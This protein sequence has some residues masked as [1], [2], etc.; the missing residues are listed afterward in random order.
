YLYERNRY[1]EKRNVPSP[2]AIPLFG[3]LGEFATNPFGPKIRE[4]TLKYG[5]TYGIYEGGTPVLVTSDLDV[6]Q[7]VFVRKYEN[8]HG[9]KEFPLAKDPDQDKYSSMFHARGLRWKRLRAISTPVFSVKNMRKLVPSVGRCV[10]RFMDIMEQRCA[11][12]KPFDILHDFQEFTCDAIAHVALGETRNLQ[13]S[14]DNPYL[15]LCREFFP[16]RPT[17]TN[18][19]WQLLPMILPEIREGVTKVYHFYKGL[20]KSD[21]WN[22]L[23]LRVTKVVEDRKKQLASVEG[24]EA[25]DFVDLF[26]EAE[27]DDSLDIINESKTVDRRNLVF[28]RKLL[29]EEIVGQLML[30]L[31]AGY[32]TTSNSLGYVAYHLAMDPERQEKLR[33]EVLDVTQGSSQI[34]YEMSLDLKYTEQCIKE[35]L[36]LY[37]LASFVQARMCMEPCTVGKDDPIEVPKGLV[38]QVDAWSIQRDKS[39]WGEDP[40]DFRPERFD[41]VDPTTQTTH[42]IPFGSGPRICIGMRFSLMEQKMLLAR[43]LQKYRIRRCDKTAV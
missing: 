13:G 38:I 8:F 7:D 37:P 35:A 16:E 25:R 41:E 15:D 1:F 36:R 11:G 18:S 12:Q 34:T 4:W 23:T 22:Q 27:S 43:L 30:L 6:Y 42:W 31:I 21:A 29:T 19:F 5:K 26:L 2:P 10:Q 40:E 39:V 32:E 28:D 33:Q 9:R 3:H 17:F 20:F 14:L 24:R